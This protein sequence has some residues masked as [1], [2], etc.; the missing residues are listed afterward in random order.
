[1]KRI[2]PIILSIIL[3]NTV[4]HGISADES[5]NNSVEILYNQRRFTPQK[6]EVSAGHPVTIRVVN[7]SKERIEFESFKLNREEVVDPGRTIVVH[8]PA[9]RPG[10][11]DFYDDFHKDVP[12][13]AIVAK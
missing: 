7:S 8:L 9:L 10:T 1:M 4:S 11:Y 6:A 3:V 2:F 5:A 12:E 13:G